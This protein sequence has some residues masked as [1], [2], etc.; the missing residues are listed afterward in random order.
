[1]N[2]FLIDLDGSIDWLAF[3]LQ[4]AMAFAGCI[5]LGL[6]MLE[7]AWNAARVTSESPSTA[8]SASASA[9]GGHLTIDAQ[10]FSA[11]PARLRVTGVTVR[12]PR[13]REPLG[14]ASMPALAR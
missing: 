9:A 4:F 12:I 2:K 7:T 10:A 14:R 13:M 6:A 1:M 11:A 3:S 8:Q 5:C